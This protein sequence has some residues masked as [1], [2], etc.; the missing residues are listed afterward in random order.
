MHYQSAIRF[1][2]FF[3]QAEMKK[4]KDD[5]ELVEVYSSLKEELTVARDKQKVA[6]VG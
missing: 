2:S 5:S 4:L 1:E 3:L 6:E